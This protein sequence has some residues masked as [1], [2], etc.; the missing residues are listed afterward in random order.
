MEDYES[1]IIREAYKR[2]GSS[3][4]L[5]EYLQISQTKANKLIQKYITQ[6]PKKN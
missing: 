3:R 1:N 6:P 4:K 5:A 2:A